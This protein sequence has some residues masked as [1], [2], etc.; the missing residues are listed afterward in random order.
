MRTRTM[1]A[2]IAASVA[3]VAMLTLPASAAPARHRATYCAKPVRLR[4]PESLRQLSRQFPWT[5]AELLSQAT[6]CYGFQ[7]PHWDGWTRNLGNLLDGH[8]GRDILDVKLPKG[9][10]IWLP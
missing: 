3:A 7:R 8:W 2:L 5:P 6:R 1:F 4:H 10:R 9:T